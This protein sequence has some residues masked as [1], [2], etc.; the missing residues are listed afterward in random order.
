MWIGDI[1]VEISSSTTIQ[2]SLRAGISGRKPHD[3]PTRN[4]TFSS[5]KRQGEET[6][7]HNHDQ[8]KILDYAC[9]VKDLERNFHQWWDYV[10][11]S[12]MSQDHYVLLDSHCTRQVVGHD[13]EL[14]FVKPIF[15]ISVITTT[16]Y[17]SKNLEYIAR[18]YSPEYTI[19]KFV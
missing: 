10:A 3:S 5:L 14:E 8:G 16:L 15:P 1:S 7:R 9:R 6:W 2:M 12:V 11:Q 18:F 4:V 19:P 13:M 17:S